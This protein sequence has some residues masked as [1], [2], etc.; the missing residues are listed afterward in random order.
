[1]SEPQGCS[2][3]DELAPARYQAGDMVSDERAVYA[4][5]LDECGACRDAVG[6]Q[7]RLDALLL[8]LPQ[9]ETPSRKERWVPSR[10]RWA[11]VALAIA[12]AAV[13]LLVF[14]GRRSPGGWTVGEAVA[15]DAVLARAIAEPG[16]RA[17]AVRPEVPWLGFVGCADWIVPPGDGIY[18]CALAPRGPLGSAGARAGDVLV[19]VE[20][21]PV[22][23]TEEMYI[24]FGGRDVGERV[25][26]AFRSG[27]AVRVAVVELAE[28]RL[29]P[30]HPF[31]LEWSPALRA[32]LNRV[33]PGGV[34]VLAVFENLPDS[35]TARLGITSGVR[36]A[37]EPTREQSERSL[38]APLP[39]LFGRGGL[40]AGDII[41]AVNGG[42]V[43]DSWIIP[44]LMKMQHGP[45][46]MSVLR[47]GESL[48][49]RF[50]PPPEFPRKP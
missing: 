8:M 25:R 18:L 39:Y 14:P 46:E 42:P 43:G 21:R 30:R 40:R 24:A 19:S 50:I 29:G 32:S 45:F 35:V 26:V 49:L 4:E 27:K 13:L 47:G 34:D 10:R 16:V 3:F 17:G 31:D 9:Y 28:R 12:A 38:L 7:R 22:R 37:L 20:G 15:A 1:M 48:R 36:V 41:T 5:H 23:R 6:R 2:D 11:A 33:P 44:A